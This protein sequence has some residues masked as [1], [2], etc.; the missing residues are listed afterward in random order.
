MMD[1]I[2][3]LSLLA[4]LLGMIGLWRIFTK[5]GRKGWHSLIPFLRRYEQ[6]ICARKES[7][8]RAIVLLEI[9]M[10]A[11]FVA[12]ALFKRGS[13]Q[14]LVSAMVLLIILIPLTIFSLRI[15]FGLCDSFGRSRLWVI[16][17]L[18]AEWLCAGIWGFV[19]GFRTIEG[20]PFDEE[21]AAPEVSGLEVDLTA[22]GL[23]INID[24]RTAVNFLKTKVLLKDIHMN[25]PLGHLVLLLGGSGAGKTTFLNAVTGYEKAKAVIT[26]GDS[27]V[28]K[29]YNKMKYDIGFVPQQDLVRGSDTVYRTL[30]DAA[31]LRLPADMKSEVRRSR[32]NEVLDIFGLTPVK[33]SLVDKLSGGQRKRLS[34]AMEYISD[35]S[36]FILDEPDSGLDGVMARALFEKLRDIADSGKIV[37]VIT[38]TPDRVA[39][40]FD[41]VIVVAKDV[42]RTGRLAYYGP[43]KEAYSF[44]GKNSMEEILMSIN[45]REEGGEGRA[46]DF[47]RKY[48]ALAAGGEA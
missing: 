18:L 35:P 13:W 7:E 27:N 16:L 36:L 12:T 4:E 25:I 3:A 19:P 26:L 15:Y 42:R 44:F 11:A 1:R 29:E 47:V 2:G 20:Y 23:S 32:I 24:R 22:P 46:D 37:I 45:R 33:S 41:D 28:Y 8:G 48:A 21:S 40:L 5:C 14:Y 38:H 34:I 43:I 30:S 39:D 9:G 10:Q 31:S 6:G 17:W